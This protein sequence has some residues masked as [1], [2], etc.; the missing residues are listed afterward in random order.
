EEGRADLVALYYLY[1]A[2]IQELG[3]VDDWKSLGKTAYND[4]IRNGLMTQLVRI[5]P[6]QDIEEAHMRNRQWVSAWVY[7]KGKADNVIERIERNGKTYFKINDY[8]K[9]HK[10]FGDLLKETQ[11]IKSEGDY[12]AGKALVENYGVKVDQQLH[13]E[14]L[15]RNKKFNIAPYRGFVNPVLV[16]VTNDNGEITDVVV[17]YPKTFTEQMLY[18]AK[19]YNFLPL[20]N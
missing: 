3:L 19:N 2:K 12:V 10:L 14:V 4:Y 15:E 8:D 11:R 17:T 7:E 16:P 18:Y 13:K 20:E 9:L 1:D 5:E 6:G